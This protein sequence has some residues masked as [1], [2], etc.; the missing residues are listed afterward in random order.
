MSHVIKPVEITGHWTCALAI[1]LRAS[2]DGIQ[3]SYHKNR[4]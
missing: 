4:F 3:I 1:K 2:T